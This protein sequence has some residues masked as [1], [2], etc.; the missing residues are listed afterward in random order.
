MNRH[1]EIR[2]FKGLPATRSSIKRMENEVK[3]LR[4]HLDELVTKR[5]YKPEESRGNEIVLIDELKETIEQKEEIILQ[6]KLLL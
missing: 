6:L 2:N 1:R 4:N 3:K 5:I